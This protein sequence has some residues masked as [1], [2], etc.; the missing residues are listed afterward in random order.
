MRM[1]K[2]C[3][4]KIKLKIIQ[5]HS[6]NHVAGI[7]VLKAFEPSE[8]FK[9]SALFVMSVLTLKKLILKAIIVKCE[10]VVA[11]LFKW[12]QTQNNVAGC[13]LLRASGPSRFTKVSPF[14]IISVLRMEN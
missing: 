8:F 6:S 5:P 13:C 2:C 11:V 7:C 10:N 9:L 3:S 14:L 12:H 1:L 4:N